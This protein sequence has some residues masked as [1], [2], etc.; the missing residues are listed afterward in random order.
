MLA[1]RSIRVI[2][3]M[4]SHIQPR[5]IHMRRILAASCLAIVGLFFTAAPS[6][7]QNPHFITGPT[8]TCGS[9]NNSVCLEVNFKAAG[10]GNVSETNYSL[11]CSSITVTGQCFTRSGNPV[12]GTT[13]SG[14]ATGTASGTLPVHNGS[15]SGPIDACPGTTFTFNFNPGCTGSQEFRVQSAAY[16]GCTLTVDGLSQDMLSATC[17]L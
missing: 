6:F 10:L 7:A 1:P 16:S 15:T 2:G 12:N 8:A 17:P 5:E 3:V 4:P 13:K 14:S 9:G 11:S